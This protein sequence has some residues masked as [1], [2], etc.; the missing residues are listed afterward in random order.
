[1]RTLPPCRLRRWIVRTHTVSGWA[2]ICRRD[3]R[4][5][6]VR[7]M[8][9]VH[10][11]VDGGFQ[12]LGLPASVRGRKE[13]FSA[14]AEWSEGWGWWGIEP[15]AII[16]MED[17]LLGLGRFRARGRTSGIEIDEEYAQVITL[18]AGTG[19]VMHEHDFIDWREGFVAAGLDPGRF[20]GLLDDLVSRSALQQRGRN[21]AALDG[22]GPA[23]A[24]PRPSV[25]AIS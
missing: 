16:D 18:R 1:M 2:A 20:A 22:R 7:Y 6:L 4:L 17:G 25:R 19:M 10:Y 11:Q 15:L 23:V 8:P 9:D 21:A 12:G 5:T 3:Y 14:L 24:K 13:M